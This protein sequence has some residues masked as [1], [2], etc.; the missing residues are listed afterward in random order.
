M[1]NYVT[2]HALWRGRSGLL[3]LLLLFLALLLPPRL[4]AQGQQITVKG[5]I[6]SPSGEK[7]PGAA[8]ALKGTSKGVASDANGAFSIEVPS[9][10]TIRI[11]FIGYVTQEIRLGAT[12]PANLTIQLTPNNADLN[13]VI[14]VG[15][16]KQKRSD[17]TGSIVSINEQSLK[18]T[19]VPNISAALQGQ[20]AGVDVQK[21]GGN[22]KPGSTPRILIRGNRSLNASNDPL[23]VVDGIPFNGNIND[24]N[25][26]DV[27]SVEVLK[28]ASAT[29][30]YGS[31]GA[32]GVIL[33]S[34]RR[35]RIGKA[36]VNYAGYYGMV[37]NR[38]K[39]P[40]MNGEEFFTF[41]KWAKYWGEI[42]SS[43]PFTGID[44]PR[45]NTAGDEF[46]AT[47]IESARTG[48]STDWQDLIYK[49]GMNTNHQVS[50]TGG[51]ESTL[52]AIS[53]GYFK[54]TGIYPGQSF[55]RYTVKASVDQTFNERLKVGLSSLN[56]YSVTEGEGANPMGQALRANPLSLPY[57]SAGNL[58]GFVEANASQ[59]WNPL[60]NFVKD[61]AVETRKRFGT[62]T[63]LYLDYEFLPGLKYRFNSG[64][65]IRTDVYGNF[66]ASNTTNN[67]GALS[68]SSNRTRF[69]SNYTLENLLTYDKIFAKKHR[70]NLTGMYSYQQSN[71]QDNTFNNQNLPAD[72]LQYFGPQYGANLTGDG[73]QE[74]WAI[75]SYMG[76]LNYGFD[77]RY[78]LTLTVRSDGSSR[79]APG[80]YFKMFPSMALTWNIT[81]ETFLKNNPTFSNLRLRASYGRT[82][83]T[84]INPYQTLGSLQDVKYNYGDNNMVIGAFLASIPNKD[85]T[86]EYTATW[87]GGLDFG[88]FN[89]RIS[90]AIEVYK[91]FTSDL[92]LPKNLPPTSGIQNSILLNVGKTENFG[93]EFQLSSVNVVPKTRNDF[94]W[95]TD[96]NFMINRGKIT[97]LSDGITRDISNNWFVGYPIGSIYD[98]RRI[99]IWQN[100]PEDS[101]AARAYGQTLTGTGS[102]IGNIRYDDA[103]GN[104]KL[105]T[106]DDRVILGSGQPDWEGGMTNRFTFRGFD[107][108]VA[109]F[110]R[111]GSTLISN[112]HRSG[113]SFTNTFQSNYNNL[114]VNYWTPTNHENR[115][116]K[117][118][119]AN[120]NS[121]NSNTLSYFDGSY[122]KIRSI[123]LGYNLAPETTRRLG[124]K[125]VR[126]YSTVEDPFILFSPYVN[127]F[128]GLDPESAGALAVDTP[129]TWSLIFGLNVTF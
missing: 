93:F 109:A 45:L 100:T 81:N 15:Y 9:G 124:V 71:Y 22:N 11:S 103:D 126:I 40:V 54:E 7:L 128:G 39:F 48:R 47:E 114:A 50:V 30:I 32:N 29:A 20:A 98:L 121:P 61:A 88:L 75:I 90:G 67:L 119:A 16:G 104:K 56:T 72:F 38:G 4:F 44:D 46:T 84:A 18:N 33:I 91:A 74:R 105:S 120:T 27:T 25:L 92:L 77:D 70:V 6:V 58:V 53:G 94:G 5:T 57:D 117:P 122:L 78:L 110:A 118:N 28:D 21:S 129:P 36:Q 76:R 69:S 23:F 82:G 66:Y 95:T 3:A 63:N 43:D 116:P 37:K 52:Y 97:E 14:V 73:N 42:A 64:I 108:T 127:D 12:A 113:G 19:P 24:L 86:W 83:N 123:G 111:M 55:E 41:K 49:T 65:E 101:A 80:N 2:C 125:N 79:L 96:L 106:S 35:G 89:N 68:R 31:R 51:T 26:D 99:G 1:K 60:A 59:V 8:V 102:V 17:V 107:L 85:L 10:S 34:T 112:M 115:W 13:E 87:N 62:F